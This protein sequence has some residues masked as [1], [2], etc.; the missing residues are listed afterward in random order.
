[1]PTFMGQVK[2]CLKQPMIFAAILFLCVNTICAQ[3]GATLYIDFRVNSSTLETDYMSNA[4]TLERMHHLFTDS[5]RVA[6]IRQIIIRS[7]ASPEGEE[8]NNMLLAVGRAHAVGRYLTCMFPQLT[9]HIIYLQPG[10]EYW[11]GLLNRIKADTMMPFH[12]DVVALLSEPKNDSHSRKALKN[13]LTTMHNSEVYR[14]LQRNVLNHLRIATIET[15]FRK[16]ETTP[17]VTPCPDV[18]RDTIWVA[19]TDTIYLPAKVDTTPSVSSKR[20]KHYY[21]IK[22]NLLNDA[23]LLPNVSIEYALPNRWSVEAEWNVSWWNTRTTH[24]YCH[25]IQMGGMEVRKWLG[26]DSKTPLTGH[27]LAAYAMGGTY[28]VRWN[29]H[30]GYLSNWSYSGGVAYGY[31]KPL[32][33][34]INLELEVA[35]GYFGGEYDTYKYS[36]QQNDFPWQ[37]RKNLHY[38]GI[39][40]LEVSI[41]W[42]I[43]SGKNKKRSE[44]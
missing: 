31:A 14:Y 8:S 37:S 22:T 27:F 43:G 12:Q 15:V 33:T 3:E 28:D 17:Q 30:T 44:K 25:R 26:D 6:Q 11:E 10:G 21:A 4:H 19:Q 40:K 39:T 41:A 42:L 34:R 5:I 29:S 7:V 38:V 1:M 16:E 24:S 32:G 13:K 23:L 2:K 35:A 36:P 20:R 18:R 9:P